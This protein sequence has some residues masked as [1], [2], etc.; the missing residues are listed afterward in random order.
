MCHPLVSRSRVAP[1]GARVPLLVLV[2]TL[3]IGALVFLRLH[4][5]GAAPAPRSLVVAPAPP[6]P[7]T[8]TAAP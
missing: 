8:L 7:G 6:S 5:G 2:A 4:L 1:P 3:A